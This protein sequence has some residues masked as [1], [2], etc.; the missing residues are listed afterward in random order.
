MEKET[1]KH[2]LVERKTH[3]RLREYCGKTGTSIKFLVTKAV[4]L[5]LAK[6]RK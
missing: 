6:T 1:S 2:V 4:E 5:Y 3:E